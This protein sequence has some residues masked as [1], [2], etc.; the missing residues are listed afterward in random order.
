VDDIAGTIHP[1]PT[2]GE[3]VQAAALRALG[4]TLHI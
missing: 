4:H 1:H 2:P 3:A